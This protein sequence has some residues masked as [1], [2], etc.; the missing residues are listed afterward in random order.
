MAVNQGTGRVPIAVHDSLGPTIG[1]GAVALLSVSG[2]ESKRSQ[3]DEPKVQYVAAVRC[4]AS[5]DKM[6]WIC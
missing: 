5:F 4:D 1:G 2:G 3:M 6:L